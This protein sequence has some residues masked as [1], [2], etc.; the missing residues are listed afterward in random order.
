MPVHWSPL[1]QKES[2]SPI[3]LYPSFL[4]QNLKPTLTYV[5]G[6]NM[7]H[8]HWIHPCSGQELV[9]VFQEISNLSNRQATCHARFLFPQ[10]D[11]T[12]YTSN[13]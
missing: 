7:D 8:D 5:T 11:Y 10:T 12:V 1:F 6:S 9:H 3:N 4:H 13:D 2:Q